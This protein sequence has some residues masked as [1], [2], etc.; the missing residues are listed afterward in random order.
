MGADVLLDS[1]RSSLGL[2][3]L[4]SQDII[5]HLAEE[6]APLLSLDLA[7]AVFVES[8]EKFVNFRLINVLSHLLLHESNE[9][10]SVDIAIAVRVK[11]TEGFHGFFEGFGFLSSDV[12]H[13]LCFQKL[14]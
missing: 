1:S 8:C 4:R 11:R 9:L 14:L 5:E 13:L 3:H 12:G 7:V 6:V 10:V 2:G